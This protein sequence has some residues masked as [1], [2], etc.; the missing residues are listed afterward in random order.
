MLKNITTI[1]ILSL[2]FLVGAQ[3]NPIQAEFLPDIS[4]TEINLPPSL[5]AQLRAFFPVIISGEHPI[6]SEPTLSTVIAIGRTVEINAPVAQD[7]YAL[8]LE[9]KVNAEVRGNIAAITTHANVTVPNRLE[10]HSPFS[11]LK[12]FWLDYLQ[13]LM[14]TPE[15]Q[16][17]PA[18]TKEVERQEAETEVT[19]SLTISPPPPTTPSPLDSHTPLTP[20]SEPTSH[21][22]DGFFSRLANF[23]LVQPIYAQTELEELE[24]NEVALTPLHSEPINWTPLW[25][26]FQHL[27]SNLIGLWLL[28]LIVPK[29]LLQISDKLIKKPVI[30]LIG[31]FTLFIMMPVI[32]VMLLFTGLSWVISFV[33]VMFYLLGLL[34]AIP[35][36]S[37]ALG[38]YLARLVQKSVKNSPKW[39]KQPALWAVFGVIATNI[40]TNLPVVG[41]WLNFSLML[42]GLGGIFSWIQNARAKKNEG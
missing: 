27:A 31:G 19:P 12:K 10:F 23:H 34:L 29:F 11:I 26:T 15:A 35:L 36:V 14:Q 9:L 1:T 30:S 33:L 24:S 3:R 16:P 5:S 17:T 39:L 4:T 21:R 7:V 41:G 38:E 22:P 40:L 20:K 25:N 2:F 32:A 42:I 8:A 13:P 28:L 18:I 6:L 37:M